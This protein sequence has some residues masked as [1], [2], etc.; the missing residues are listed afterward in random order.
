LGKLSSGFAAGEPGKARQ[1]RVSFRE[2]ECCYAAQMQCLPVFAAEMKFS[3]V[4]YKSKLPSVKIAKVHSNKMLGHFM[5]TL[6][7][8]PRWNVAAVIFQPVSIL[9][10]YIA[11]VVTSQ[12]QSLI[13]L[14]YAIPTYAVFSFF[15]VVVGVVA[16]IRRERWPA[17]SWIGL[18]INAIPF[19]WMFSIISQKVRLW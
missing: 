6:S 15:G 9:A 8:N 10:A 11:L 1:K 16:L 18:V 2:K 12:P 13:G 4:L 3:P 17:L 5:D 14:L 19:L 7:R